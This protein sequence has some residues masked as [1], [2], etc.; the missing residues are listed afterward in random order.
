MI[1]VLLTVMAADI[2]SMTL[3]TTTDIFTIYRCYEFF[4]MFNFGFQMRLWFSD[5]IFQML[6][7][8]PLDIIQLLTFSPF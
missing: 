8:M 5:S 1:C 7:L 3:D 4:Y 6:F 2:I